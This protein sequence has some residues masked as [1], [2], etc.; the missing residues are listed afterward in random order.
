MT[1]FGE[2]PP[3]L[4]AVY[5]RQPRSQSEYWGNGLPDV[6]V[7]RA[8]RSRG[9]APS[10]PTSRWPGTQPAGWLRQRLRANPCDRLHS[11]PGARTKRHS[12]HTGTYADSVDSRRRQVILA[13]TAHFVGR[14]RAGIWL[15]FEARA[16]HAA[17]F[18]RQP[19]QAMS[20]TGYTGAIGSIAHVPGRACSQGSGAELLSSI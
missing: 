2:V 15:R 8:A 18:P 13:L 12:G 6:P 20:R 1:R 11:Q 5:Q 9:G 3:R 7:G 19:V 10:S 16:A 14:R 17:A 4:P